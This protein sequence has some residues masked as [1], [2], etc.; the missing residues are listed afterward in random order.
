MRE[1][2][3]IHDVTMESEKKSESGLEIVKNEDSEK[4]VEIAKDLNDK[5]DKNEP[6]KGEEVLDLREALRK[7]K[8]DFYGEKKTADEIKEIPNVKRNIEIYENG[9][10]IDFDEV[11]YLPKE[12]AVKLIAKATEAN[13]AIFLRGLHFISD[14]VALLLSRFVGNIYLDGLETITDKQAELFLEHRGGITLS[15]LTDL[16]DIGVRYLSQTSDFYD[17]PP[18]I[19][20]RI[21]NYRNAEIQRKIR[22]I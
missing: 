2:E 13:T 15:G 20:T 10:I 17:F 18:K 6:I 12:I 3:A 14:E 16:S 11:T 4:V 5:I 21:E 7:M 22:K 8:F 9:E 1:Q 19:K